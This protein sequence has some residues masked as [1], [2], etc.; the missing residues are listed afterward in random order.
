MNLEQELSRSTGF[1][2]RLS[3]NQGKKE[4]YDFTEINQSL[5]AGLVFQG[6]SWGRGGDTVGTAGVVNALTADARKYF[7]AG[8]V[9]ILIGDGWQN[10][11]QEMIS[12]TYYNARLSN[13]GP[14]SI[15]GI[16]LHLEF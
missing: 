1:F 6:S 13:R 14:V 11:G 3:A 4:T 15:L 16:R 12:E 2:A 10:Y 5:A 9:G 7:S 8:G